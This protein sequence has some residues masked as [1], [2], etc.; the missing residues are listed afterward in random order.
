[1]M[2]REKD[3]NAYPAN[4]L[5]EKLQIARSRRMLALKVKG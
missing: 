2:A 1:M 5:V 3:A 4:G